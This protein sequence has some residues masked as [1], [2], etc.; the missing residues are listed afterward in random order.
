MQRS[1]VPREVSPHVVSR[2]YRPPEVILL[3]RSYDERV[4]LWSCGIIL[5]EL[6]LM[7]FD[8]KNASFIRGDS[9]FP[10]SPVDR[11]DLSRVSTEND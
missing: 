6:S 7:C 3:E 1:S 5:L 11:G 9:C 10:L 2:Q 4:D 8:D